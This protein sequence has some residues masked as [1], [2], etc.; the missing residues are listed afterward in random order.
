MAAGASS[1]WWCCGCCCCWVEGFVH[2]VMVNFPRY[3]DVR[4]TPATTLLHQ[5]ITFHNP[6]HSSHPYT[7][8]QTH[9]Y[10]HGSR[11]R[12]ESET[13][14]T[15]DRTLVTAPAWCC[16]QFTFTGCFKHQL[17][18]YCFNEARKLLATV[19]CDTVMHLQPKYCSRCAINNLMSVMTTH[20][21]V[22]IQYTPALLAKTF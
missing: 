8:L 10:H 13:L 20:T 5:Q 3:V 19:M 22:Y 11:L 6:S 2:L 16:A 12:S 4:S 9:V 14:S 17:N 15:L 18:T 7:T 1:Q 21:H